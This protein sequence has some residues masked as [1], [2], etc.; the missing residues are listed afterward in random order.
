MMIRNEGPNGT[1]NSNGEPSAGGITK[2]KSGISST[3]KS[4][5]GFAVASWLQ[6]DAEE[7]TTD[8]RMSDQ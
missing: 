4:D 1:V 5:A 6:A 3:S 2:N 8:L 7:G